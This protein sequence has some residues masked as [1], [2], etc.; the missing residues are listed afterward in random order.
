[1]VVPGGWR[2]L[3]SEVPLCRALPC[4]ASL[5]PSRLLYRGTSLRKRILLG[6]YRRPT[7]RV[8]EGPRGGSVFLRAVY[9]RRFFELPTYRGYSKLRTRT[10]PRVVLCFKVA[11]P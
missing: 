9:L 3:K 5:R 4:P 6:P 1:M 11:L 8:L 10:A 7:P 2:F